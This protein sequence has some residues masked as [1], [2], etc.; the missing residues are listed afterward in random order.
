MSK[1]TENGSSDAGCWCV[2]WSRTDSP[3]DWH[4]CINVAENS[5][6]YPPMMEQVPHHLWA[7]ECRLFPFDWKSFLSGFFQECWITAF[8]CL[9][10]EHWNT[11]LL[12]GVWTSV[13][14]AIV[15]CIN[16]VLSKFPLVF[17]VDFFFNAKCNCCDL[18][19]C[20]HVH[21]VRRVY[22][23]GIHE[24]ASKIKPSLSESM[25]AAQW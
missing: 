8:H 19:N 7:Y 17:C 10:G 5:S 13:H 11:N 25:T 20:V 3:T 21:V 14:W 4:S 9:L 1:S 12:L 18:P 2:W 16:L 22:D 6:S 23:T 24:S 15:R